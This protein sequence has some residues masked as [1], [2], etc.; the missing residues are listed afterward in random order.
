MQHARRAGQKSRRLARRSVARVCPV[1]GWVERSGDER[2]VGWCAARRRCK[3]GE[4]RVQETAW[5]AGREEYERGGRG[6]EPPHRHTNTGHGWQ[7]R[8]PRRATQAP[9]RPSGASRRARPSA[10][11]PDSLRRPAAL[12]PRASR[13][14]EGESVYQ[15]DF[16]APRPPPHR[17]TGGLRQR[18]GGMALPARV[19]VPNAALRS[20]GAIGVGRA[21]AAWQQAVKR[22]AAPNVHLVGDSRGRC[23][24]AARHGLGI[25]HE[26]GSDAASG[27]IGCH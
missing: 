23:S 2:V 9:R 19:L 21:A 6:G 26:L 24:P 1:A 27:R 13:R 10:A 17:A 22:H 8:A 4:R 3:E 16:R 5:G 11:R 15:L 12:T 25:R 20:G 14:R 18:S 7:R